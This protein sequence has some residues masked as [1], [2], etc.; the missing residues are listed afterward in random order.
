MG[1]AN[2]NKQITTAHPACSATV[3]FGNRNV[4][5]DNLGRPNILFLKD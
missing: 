1:K 4:K 5:Y 3:I 2:K